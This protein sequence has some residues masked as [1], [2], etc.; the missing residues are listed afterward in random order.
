MKRTL[1]TG[2]SLLCLGS[3]AV[4]AE[5]WPQWRGPQR[6]DHSP[7]TG[8]LK[9][10]P[11]TGP[12]KVWMFENAGVG[13]SGPA[14]VD[15][16]LY[17]LGAREDEEQL[18]A[19]DAKTGKELWFA[20]LAPVYD[21]KWGDGPRSTPTIDGGV[22]YV[23]AAKGDLHA[24]D[25]RSKK[26]LWSVSM[27]KDLGGKL[28]SWGYTESPLV[29]GDQVIC[30]PGG[31]KG[32]M[33]ALNKKTGKVIWQSE[34]LTEEAWYSSPMK[35]TIQGKAQY[36][37]LCHGNLF[38]ADAKTGKILWK[39]DWRGGVAV[40]PTPIIDGNSVYIT[41]GYGAGCKKVT[42]EANGD[43]KTEYDMQ[44]E[45]MVNHHGGVIALDGHLFGHSDSGGWTCQKLSDGSIVWRSKEL[46]KGAIGYADGM[47]Y[48]LGENKGDV[49]LIEAST[50]GW[51]EKG[52]F[53]LDPQTKIR[54][55]D[56]RI[57]THPVILD[58]K[59]YLRDQ[60]LIYCYD[61]KGK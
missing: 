43:V 52:R 28:Q 19:L 46:D 45:G 60:D 24:I 25:L 16:V 36:V 54:E 58:G 55:K 21:N 3:T 20:T 15:G 7:D 18:I 5:N 32:A 56:G 35:A 51:S 40:I 37:Q 41:S 14:I 48:C 29:D 61:V 4:F 34:E 22:A 57:W 13:Y 2:F 39:T 6:I 10:W 11:S 26:S 27:T 17:T 44:K 42:I 31:K 1:L 53:V 23:M 8:L 49:V 59:L 47:L 9:S 30:T 50:S 12:K 38:G 33:A